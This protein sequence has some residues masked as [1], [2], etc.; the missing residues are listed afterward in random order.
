MRQAY[1]AFLSLL[2]FF[3]L[4]VLLKLR[5]QLKYVFTDLFFCPFSED[6]GA[7]FAFLK[8]LASGAWTYSL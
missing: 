5:S 1:T 8:N 3:M 4:H 6:D 7:Y 2:I